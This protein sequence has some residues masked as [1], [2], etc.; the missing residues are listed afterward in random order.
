MMANVNELVIPRGW[1]D[2]VTTLMMCGT[3]F[4]IP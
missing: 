4:D 2:K 1:I 3:T